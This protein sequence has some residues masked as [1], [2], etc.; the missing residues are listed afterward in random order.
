MKKLDEILDL[1]GKSCILTGAANGIGA[2][3]AFRLAEAGA[4]M[5]LLDVDEKN[6]LKVLHK[7]KVINNGVT[8]MSFALDL[9]EKSRIDAFW[10]DIDE[11]D[12]DILINNAGMFPF[13]DFLKLTEEKLMKVMQV[14]LFSTLWMCQAFIKKRLKKGGIILNFGSIEAILPF[15]KDLSHY[16]LSKIGV[17]TLTRDL[18]KEYAGEGFRVNVVLPG[19]IFTKGTKQAAIRAI[20]TLDMG[21]LKDGYLF[22]NRVPAAELGKADDVALTVL[23]LCTDM[24][25]FIHG[26]IIPVDGG[27]LCA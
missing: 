21:L 6:L 10:S 14:N 25:R 2:A 9:S 5:I 23:S 18:A 1:R 19:C 16:S 7:V 4:K 11:E 12:P 15:K 8:H 13:V 24:T 3:S 20:R 26:A 22:K 17:I 27:F